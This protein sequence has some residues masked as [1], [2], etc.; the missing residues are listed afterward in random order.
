LLNIANVQR[1]PLQIINPKTGAPIEA[2]TAYVARIAAAKEAEKAARQA[3]I[4]RK[5][6][7]VRITAPPTP[8]TRWATPAESSDAAK[9]ARAK[10]SELSAQ[11]QRRRAAAAAIERAEDE[12]REREAAEAQREEEENAAL[13]K[14]LGVE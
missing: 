12:R 14:L 10:A 1:G 5:P 8:F 2:Y 3:Y 13:M 11:A 4:K 9:A 7:V 6:V